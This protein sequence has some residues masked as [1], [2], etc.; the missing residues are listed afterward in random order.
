MAPKAEKEPKAPKADIPEELGAAVEPGDKVP[1][2]PP[3]EKHDEVNPKRVEF[4][5]VH[6]VASGLDE[7]GTVLDHVGSPFDHV[8][9]VSN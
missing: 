4:V 1:M 9:E 7:S 2:D 3:A 5:T 6:N 8:M